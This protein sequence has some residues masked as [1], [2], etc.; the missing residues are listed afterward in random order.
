[1]KN[2]EQTTGTGT[3]IMLHVRTDATSGTTYRQY[4]GGKNGKL[5]SYLANGEEG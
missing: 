4:G 2:V 1:M 3:G 5:D